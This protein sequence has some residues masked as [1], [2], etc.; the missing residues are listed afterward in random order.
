MIRPVYVSFPVMLRVGE[1]DW[2]GLDWRCVVGVEEGCI[3]RGQVWGDPVH[4]I[5]VKR[6]SCSS[7]APGSYL[8]RKWHHVRP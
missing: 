3:S 1:Q 6:T 8:S 5:V 2:K 7:T 4:L